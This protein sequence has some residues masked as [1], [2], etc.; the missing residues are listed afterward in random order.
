M[1]WDFS[2]GQPNATKTAANPIRQERLSVEMHNND[3]VLT[4]DELRALLQELAVHLWRQGE[5]GWR[6]RLVRSG[7]HRQ[8]Q[9]F[10]EVRQNVQP[11]TRNLLV[12]QKELRLFGHRHRLDGF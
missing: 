5:I 2:A 8:L 7:M 10:F 6:E 4:A 12:G 11:R 9:R 3:P 1:N